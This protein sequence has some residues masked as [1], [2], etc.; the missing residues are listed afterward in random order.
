MRI[1]IRGSVPLTNRS[2][3]LE[4]IRIRNTGTFT[5]FFKNKSLKEVALAIF[6]WIVEGIRNHIRSQIRSVL[7]NNGSGCGG[8]G[9]KQIGL[10]NPDP[11]LQHWLKSLSKRSFHRPSPLCRQ[12]AFLGNFCYVHIL[13]L[14]NPAPPPPSPA[15]KHLWASNPFQAFKLGELHTCV[16][17]WNSWTPV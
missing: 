16:L 8:G 5:T 7:V 9:P 3:R 15:K 14:E 10:T 4:N 12:G 1:W 13:F 6:A 17:R 11:K 2:G